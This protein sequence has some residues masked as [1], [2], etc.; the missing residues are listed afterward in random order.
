MKRALVAL[1]CTVTLILTGCADKLVNP[2]EDYVISCLKTVS[3]ITDIEAATETHDPN[4]E[5]HKQGGYTA[6]I[7]F[8]VDQ[9]EI[10]E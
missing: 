3:G 8:R 6:A 10:K 5:L 9:I 4:G 1:I 2:K 7:Y